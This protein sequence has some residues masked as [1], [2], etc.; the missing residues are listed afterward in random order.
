MTR[1]LGGLVFISLGLIGCADNSQPAGVNVSAPGVEVKVGPEGTSVAAPG[2]NVN[3]GADGAKVAAPGVNVNAGGGGV[4]V[5]A[6]GDAP[7]AEP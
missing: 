2:V 5:K 6:G 4:D 7:K 1:R 3:A